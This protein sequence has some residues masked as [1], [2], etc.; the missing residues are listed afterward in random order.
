MANNN[1][2]NPWAD[3]TNQAVGALYKYYMSKPTA[4]DQLKNQYMQSQ[5]DQNSMEGMMNQRLYNMGGYKGMPASA[6]EFLFTQ[7]LPS[8][9]GKRF[10]DVY[11]TKPSWQDLGDRKVM[12][13]VNGEMASYNVGT[14][15]RMEL[16]KENN[17]VVP[18]PASP[19]S[20]S[21][22]QQTPISN[23]F[24][25]L[26][27]QESGGNPNALSPKGA[28]GIAQIMPDTARDPGY[29]VQ[30]LQNWD[31]VDPRTA[32]VEEQMR[33]GQDYMNAMINNRGGNVAEGL[34]AYNAGPGAV[35]NHGGIP[36][37]P[38]T[39]QYVQNVMGNA[40]VPQGGGMPIQP[41]PL[42]K[43]AGDI[44]R[45]N[46]KNFTQDLKMSAL[47]QTVSSALYNIQKGGAGM[48]SY[49]K[50]IPF[51]GGQTAAGHLEADL[52]KI[53]NA[54]AIDEIARLKEESKTGGF[55][56][57]LSDG[58]RQAVAD[59]QLAIRQA[60]NPQELAYR[61]L[62]FQDLKNDIIFRRG[63]TDPMTGE[64]VPI[65]SH[66]GRSGLPSMADIHNAQTTQELEAMWNAFDRFP[67]FQG[68]PPQMID[69]A[70][71]DRYNQ[72]RGGQ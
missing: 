63:Q 21:F 2:T 68:R 28:A 14:P 17:Q 40:N 33:F 34:A 18:I 61:L 6:Q 43:P 23:L 7:S 38:E 51:V 45:E 9:A 47:D 32:P 27:Q 42:S 57:N 39:Q 15:P 8:D 30:P 59:S 71:A 12:M 55:F 19:S 35:A 11:V 48:G 5:I 62:E 41:I 67:V 65:D 69:D 13:G 52:S 72:L 3:A 10:E 1:P 25:A 37:Y 29:G 66:G 54:A 49:A 26:I 20:G 22:T 60:M 58:E 31:G 4:A 53:T 64:T 36:P 50:D 56:G 70:L 44:T 24:G 46:D 16:D